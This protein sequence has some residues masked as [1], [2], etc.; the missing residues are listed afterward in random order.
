MTAT[1]EHDLDTA[2]KAAIE[3]AD[4]AFS[5]LPNTEPERT[6][7]SGELPSAIDYSIYSAEMEW[8]ED[9]LGRER[10]DEEEREYITAW[11]ERIRDRREDEGLA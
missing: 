9:E 2:R 5:M 6:D 7:Q 1:D 4:E 8:L 10:T 11:K 3:S